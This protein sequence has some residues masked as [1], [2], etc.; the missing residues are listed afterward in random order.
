MQLSHKYDNEQAELKRQITDIQE[1]LARLDETK[2]LK[3]SFIKAVRK[4]ME[5]KTLTHEILHEL[6]EKIEVYQIVG[7]GKSRVQQIVIH[8]RFVGC[9]EIPDAPQIVHALDTRQ[10]VRVSYEVIAV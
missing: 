8:Y 5:M 4:F 1:Q 6:I 3:E 2:P 10:G 9:I 7:T